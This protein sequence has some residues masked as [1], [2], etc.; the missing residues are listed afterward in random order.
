MYKSAITLAG[1]SGAAL[2]LAA[3]AHP[4]VPSSILKEESMTIEYTA[5]SGESVIRFE[6]ESEFPLARAQIRSPGGEAL[7]DIQAPGGVGLS[8]QGF[9]LETSESSIHDLFESYPEGVYPIRARTVDGYPA[10]GAAVL[11]H[12]LLRP[13]VVTFPTEG[14]VGVPVDLTVRW[15]NDPRAAGYEV[16]LEQGE[17]DD[18]KVLLPPNSES[19]QVSPGVLE[20]GTESKV[21]V[22]AIS[23]G[24]NC[25]LIEVTFTTR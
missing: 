7:F 2:A 22:G 23:S 19:F 14:S 5:N 8:L 18:L 1:L 20:S 25:T 16:I 13:P 21:E 24:G 9:L 12:D 11:S 10:L 3:N 6:A 15:V 4:P 17:N